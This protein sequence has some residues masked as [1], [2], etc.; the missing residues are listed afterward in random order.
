[1]LFGVHSS[2]LSLYVELDIDLRGVH[3]YGLGRKSIDRPIID[4]ASHGGF[5]TAEVQVKGVRNLSPFFTY[6]TFFP[7]AF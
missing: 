7:F 5:L 2:S 3:I 1:M 4:L 6:I